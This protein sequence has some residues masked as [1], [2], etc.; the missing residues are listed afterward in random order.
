VKI[1][2]NLITFD[3]PKGSTPTNFGILGQPV[4][5]QHFPLLSAQYYH[6]EAAI[7]VKG[8]GS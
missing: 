2:R 4:N 3:E 1:C 8:G 5:I 6:T 7:H